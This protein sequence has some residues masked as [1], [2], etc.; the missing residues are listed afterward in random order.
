MT[1]SRWVT[2]AAGSTPEGRLA[3]AQHVGPPV[4]WDPGM[5]PDTAHLLPPAP[6]AAPDL[7]DD[8]AG[9]SLRTDLWIEHYL[10]HWT[11]P[12]RSVARYDLGPDGLRLRIDV[13]QQDWR[14][15]DAPLRVSNLQTATYSGPLG[16]TRGTHRHRPDGLVVR[17]STPTRL[18][19]APRAGRVDVTLTASADPGCVLAA[20]LVGTEHLSGRD[21]GEICLLEI[22][23]DA[24]G[25]R[26]CR[27][28]TGVKAHH[29]DRLRTDMAEVDV[30]IAGDQPHTWTAIWGRGG[31]LIGCD[32]V[33]LRRHDQAPDYPMVL[34]IDLFEVGPRSAA[35]AYPKSARLHRVVG[36]SDPVGSGS[37]S[38]T[39]GAVPGGSGADA[40]GAA[41]RR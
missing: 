29:D 26:S 11:T 5:A 35:G 8:F 40:G 21:S 23:G 6:D 1:A 38:T 41:L 15:E 27:V 33:V 24:V 22:D 4:W 18:L 28:R 2:R 37:G 39:P 12:D 14:E 7:E 25:A 10:P 34:M 9:P 31:T 32:G 20:W 17:T 36:W 3:E 30:P 13:D 16:S 19:W